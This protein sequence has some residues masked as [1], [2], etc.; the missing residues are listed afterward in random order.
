MAIT[1]RQIAQMAGVSRG[2]VDKVIHERPGVSEAVRAQVKRILREHRYA[3]NSIAKAL[4]SCNKKREIGVIL[5]MPEGN[6][7]SMQ[8]ERGVRMAER[9]LAQ[10]GVACRIERMQR[11][12][13]ADQAALMLTLRER[14]VDGIVVMGL[15]G[16]HTCRAVQ[17]VQVP[18]VSV[19]SDIPGS[20]CYVGHDLAQGA[21]MAAELLAKSVR[22]RGAIA[23][24][25]GPQSMEAHRIRRQAFAD[26]LRLQYPQAFICAEAC[27]HD[28]DADSYKQMRAWLR[29]QP[30]IRG[31]YVTGSGVSGVVQALCDMRREDIAIVCFDLSETTEALLRQG[32]VDFVIDHDAQNEGFLAVN[33]LA[34][35]LLDGLQ[36]KREIFT[37]TRVYL[38]ENL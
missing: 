9:E 21:R 5:M 30:D 16:E 22:K 29:E 10:Q 11:Y 37:A 7:Y 36:P 19:T 25:Y 18:V 38:R 14:G 13:E 3:P 15:Q 27:N 26:H 32:R 23:M 31:V 34:N 6:Q 17:E 1:I 8:V 20:L 24:L 12:A 4:S 2:T 33:T 35:Y 28:L